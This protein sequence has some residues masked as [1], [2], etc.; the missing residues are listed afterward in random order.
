MNPRYQA[1]VLQA[2]KCGWQIGKDHITFL[3]QELVDKVSVLL[4]ALMQLKTFTQKNKCA[5]VMVIISSNS[6]RS[7]FLHIFPFFNPT[8]YESNRR[9]ETHCERWETSEVHLSSSNIVTKD[10]EKACEVICYIMILSWPITLLEWSWRRSAHLFKCSSF[11]CGL[12]DERM[13]IKQ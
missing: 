3:C 6:R 2:K 9:S 1:C 7:S 8:L 10:E 12:A 5:V 13:F 4:A 11:S